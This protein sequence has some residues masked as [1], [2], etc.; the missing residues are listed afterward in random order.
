MCNKRYPQMGSEQHVPP[1][2]LALGRLSISEFERTE[3]H[4]GPARAFS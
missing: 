1:S 4:P 3:Y 2:L